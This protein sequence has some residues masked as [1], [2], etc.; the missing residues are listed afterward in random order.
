VIKRIRQASELRDRVKFVNRGDWKSTI[1]K[2]RRLAYK[3]RETFFYFDPPFYEKADRLYRYYFEDQDHVDLCRFLKTFNRPWLLSYDNAEEIAEMYASS[4]NG[5]NHVEHLYSIAS[6][7]TRQKTKEL[8]ITN[9]KR[10]PAT[11]N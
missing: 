4:G 3:P 11:A 7:G 6:A 1:K 10:L 5:T 2:V 8:F 9:L